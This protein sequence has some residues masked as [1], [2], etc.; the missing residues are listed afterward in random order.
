MERSW[1]GGFGELE[2]RAGNENLGRILGVES[3][4][5][6]MTFFKQHWTGGSFETQG[7]KSQFPVS[8]LSKQKE[9]LKRL[10]GDAYLFGIPQ[11][12]PF[13]DTASTCLP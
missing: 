5:G 7:L 12:S 1:E 6:E 4:D 9:K 10:P 8:T 2:Q 3:L 11:A 13:D